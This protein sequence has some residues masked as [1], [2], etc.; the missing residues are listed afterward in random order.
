[1][2]FNFIIPVCIKN[3]LHLNQLYRCISSVRKFHPFN[4][5]YLIDDSDD[6]FD[7]KHLFIHDEKIFIIKSLNKGSGEL[8]AFKIILDYDISGKCFI[9]QDSMMLNRELENID[10]IKN[11]KFLWHFTNHTLH[12]DIIHEPISEFNTA[13]N[14]II[15]TDLIKYHLLNDYKD[16]VEFLNFALN[17]LQHKS[18]WCGSL[19][20]CCMIDKE[21]VLFMNNEINFANKFI[22]HTERRNRVVN[23]SIFALICHFYF[24]EVDFR[25]SYDGLYYDGINLNS[26]HGRDT[27]FDNLTWC[28]KNKYVSKVSF[29]R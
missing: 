20:N 2:S 10:T 15:H 7:I 19:G 29:G 25:D 18:T 24:P 17:A 9:M 22:A 3:S 28:A 13:N 27:G 1:M 4:R 11:V 26:D 14:I 16:N 8:Q 5:I 21:T 23:E 12:W 6:C